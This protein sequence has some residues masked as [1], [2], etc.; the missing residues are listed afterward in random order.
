MKKFL[1]ALWM[2]FGMFSVIPVPHKWDEDAR[3]LMTLLLPV[4]GVVIGALWFALASLLFWLELPIPVTAAFLMMFP[5]LISG[6]MHLDGYMDCCDAI[7]SR[8]SVEEKQ[9]ILKD[10]KVGSFAVISLG[11]LF[12]SGFGFFITLAD[13]PEILSLILIPIMSRACAGLAVTLL[14]P[15]NHSQY[16][17]SYRNG[18]KKSHIVIFIMETAVT[19]GAA[20]IYGVLWPL[21]AAAVCSWIAIL[22]A[23]YQLGGMS[24]DVAGYSITI[25]EICAVAVLILI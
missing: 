23:K 18:V 4:V 17:S 9:R 14:R 16:S 20:C 11:I 15:M 7:L 13:N 8:R 24:G 10:P 22:Y 25:S 1:T 5:Y 21:L 3:P 6:F 12:I 2:A 19:F